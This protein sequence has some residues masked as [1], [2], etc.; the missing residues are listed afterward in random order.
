M[1]IYR[2]GEKSR[3]I[4]SRCAKLVKTTFQV[5][6]VPTSSGKTIVED[7]LTSVCDECDLVVAIPQQSAP[8]IKDSFNKAR[9]S[10]E[11]RVPRHLLDIL[12]A[13]S[14]SFDGSD[15]ASRVPV[16]LKYYIGIALEDSALLKNIKKLK[17]SDL[18][19]GKSESRLSIKVDDPLFQKFEAIRKKTKL[20]KADVIKSIILQ[21]HEDFLQKPLAKK[22]A[23]EVQHV[24]YA[25]A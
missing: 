3:G 25:A 23:I 2:E 1:K 7:I 17:S 10:I 13:A 19:K 21:V 8:R 6:S 15:Y 20:S 22:R 9:R 24:L 16:I 4:C 5:R 18:R 14:A 11:V 12:V